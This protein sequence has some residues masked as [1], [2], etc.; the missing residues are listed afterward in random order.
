MEVVS[1]PGTPYL[2]IHLFRP[3]PGIR[4]EPTVTVLAVKIHVHCEFG[5][6][7]STIESA[8]V[9]NRKL[10]FY[11][12]SI[13]LSVVLADYSALTFPGWVSIR[14]ET[15][16]PSSVIPRSNSRM[17]TPP[18]LTTTS[19]PP[20]FIVRR[21]AQWKWG[22]FRCP[23]VEAWPSV[24]PRLLKGQLPSPTGARISWI[25]GYIARTGYGTK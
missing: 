2:S 4:R 7:G 1:P 3:R 9:L 10:L 15:S 6:G 24:L 16:L 25:R 14:Q 21:E 20:S 11:D 5:V 22:G 8:T 13:R 18:H 17:E 19:H 23:V 12:C